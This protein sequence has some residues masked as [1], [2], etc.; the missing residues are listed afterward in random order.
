M[1][2]KQ[3]YDAAIEVKE[4]NGFGL[5]LVLPRG[6]KRPQGFPRGELLCQNSQGQ[7]VYSFDPDKI[8][9]WIKKYKLVEG[10]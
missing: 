4:R 1:S 5:P 9:N 3:M 6:F 8:I 10:V 2:P 7:R